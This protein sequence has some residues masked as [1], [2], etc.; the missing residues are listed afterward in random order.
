SGFAFTGWSGNASGGANPLALTMNGNK[1]VSAGF[2]DVAPPLATVVAPNGGETFSIGAS[3]NLEWTALDNL[4]VTAVDLLV[5]HDGAA[6]T[7]DLIAAGVA[8]SASFPWPV[9]APPTGDPALTPLP[10]DPAP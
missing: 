8:N 6:G 9:P 5:S 1:T 2:A 3:A 4:G 7:Y 10:H